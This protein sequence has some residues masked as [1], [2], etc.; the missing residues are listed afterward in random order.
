MRAIDRRT[1]LKGMG[2]AGGAVVGFNALRPFAVGADGSVL[3]YGLA[4][5]DVR[6]LDPMGGPNSTDK[7]VLEHIYRG[8]VRPM[9]GEVNAERFQPDLAEN[10]E[11]S[12]DLKAWT[13]KLRQGVEF[14]GGF[15]EFTA[16]DVEFSLNRAR[17]KKTSIY[18]KFY[19]EFD[20]VKALDKHTVR[21]TLKTPQTRIALLPNLLGWQAGMIMSRKAAEKLGDKL[22]T[23]PIGTGPFAFK[24]HVPQER[25]VLVRN[26]QY[27]LGKPGIGGIDFRFLPDAS[28]RNLAFK[29][30]ELH[31][32]ELTREQRAINQVKGPDVVIESFGPSTVVKLHMDRKRK[33]LDDLRVRKAIAHSINR[34][35]LVRFIGPDV[36]SSL[37][38]VIPPT[39]VGALED[40]PAELRYDYNPEKA[41]QLLADAGMPKGFNLNPVFIS[42]KPMFR[43][44]AEVLQNQMAQVGIGVNLSVIAHPAWHKKNDEGSNPLVL[45]AATRFPTANFILEEFFA[46]GAKRNFSHFNGADAD[47]QQAKKETDPQVQKKLWGDAQTKI[48]ED[49]AALPTHEIKNVYARKSG[50]ELG[51]KLESDLCICVPLKWDARLM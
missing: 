19:R 3:Q 49:L 17:N 16:D 14:H 40:V 44:A 2:V 21:I 7:T 10:W 48:L 50:V 20:D 25:L 11:H 15:G 41:K 26:D 32:I 12:S 8:L 31:I 33:P 39:F 24:E 23:H 13:F 42:E 46:K 37:Y 47:I 45:R 28:S 38:S 1:F 22:K 34:D 27:H 29:A 51:F 4:A 6:R 18:H 30:G 5:A 9:P 36:A 43:R 35:A